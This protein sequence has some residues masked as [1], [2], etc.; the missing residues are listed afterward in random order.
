VPRKLVAYFETGKN[1]MYYNDSSKLTQ[2]Y[3]IGK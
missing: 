1:E 3:G 2:G